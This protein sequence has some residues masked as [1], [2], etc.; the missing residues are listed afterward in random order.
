MNILK[1]VINQSKLLLFAMSLCLVFVGCNETGKEKTNNNDG[2]DTTAT[3]KKLPDTATVK[4]TLPTPETA[5][6]TV[7]NVRKTADGK[8]IEVLFNERAQ[9]F[10]FDITDTAKVN[11]INSAF[12]KNEPLKINVDA[13]AEKLTTA[14]R[15]LPEQARDLPIVEKIASGKPISLSATKVDTVKLNTVKDAS[16]ALAG[17]CTSWVIPNYATAVT[18]FNFCAS[19]SCSISVSSPVTPCI[20][21]QYVLDGCYARAHK[22]K[23]IIEDRY[24]YCTQKVFS[25]ANINNKT[26]AVRAAKWGNCCVRWWYHVAPV[27]IVNINGQNVYYVIDPGMF[28]TPVTLATWLAAQANTGCA[29]NAAVTSYSIQPATAYAPANYTGTSFTTDP[30]YSQT[31]AILTSYRYLKTCP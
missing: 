18:I 7:A 29:A 13:V 23:A 24:K 27:I 30:T 4:L 10:K 15:L 3:S 1:K 20:P 6:L 12:K 17:G 5:V 25:F 19:N 21:F 2:G 16:K 8:S 28:N 22:M 9:I 31:N 14:E 26:L 11:L